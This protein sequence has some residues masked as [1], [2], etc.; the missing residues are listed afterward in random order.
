MAALQSG[1]RRLVVAEDPDA[2][3]ARQL[4]T[5]RSMYRLLQSLYCRLGAT[6]RRDAISRA[7]Q[8]GLLG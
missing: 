6:S 7:R 5:E 8:R 3:L 1:A 2:R 4:D